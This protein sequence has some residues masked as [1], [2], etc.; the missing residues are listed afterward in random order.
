VVDVDGC[1]LRRAGNIDAISGGIS[2]VKRVH[3]FEV[4]VVRTTRP[5]LV[6]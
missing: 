3:P 1:V 6:N 5:G 2:L 4:D